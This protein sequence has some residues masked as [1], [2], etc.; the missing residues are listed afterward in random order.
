MYTPF[1]QDLKEQI[2]QLQ[3]DFDQFH[4]SIDIGAKK[5]KLS[6]LESKTYEAGFW[7]DNTNAGKISKE[8]AELKDFIETIDKLRDSVG[9]LVGLSNEKGLESEVENELRKTQ[10]LLNEQKVL[11]YLSGEFD[12]KNAIFSIHAGQGGTEA[13]DW[14][15]MLLRMY[16]RF[17]DI[18]G[19]KYEV[20][21]QSDGEEA[22]IKAVTMLVS[23]R[24]C[25]GLLKGEAGTHRL[26]RQSPF[27]ADKLRQ[28]SF[29]LVE[30]M[31]EIDETDASDIDIRDD[32]LEWQFYRSGGAGGQNVNKV[33]TAVR[34]IHTPSGIVVTSQT[35]RMQQQNR[36]NALSLLRSKLWIREQELAKN[37][38][39]AIKG[40]YQPAAWGT[41][42]RSYV[43]HPYKMVKDLRTA[44]ET[45]NAESVL[46]GNLDEFINAELSLA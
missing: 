27:N 10:K 32:D 34:L 30:V 42:I 6:E 25:Y 23:G 13:M 45:S 12:N 1:M 40:N 46:D 26:V 36:E 35:Q 43:L 31:P 9:V 17:F 18:K 20:L 7:D 11:T 2:K 22:G 14:S 33:S 21:D 3:I 24:N 5:Q 4:E 28:T 39:S 15:S 41:Q 38:E 29:S 16:T 8:V 44:V 37:K 19:W